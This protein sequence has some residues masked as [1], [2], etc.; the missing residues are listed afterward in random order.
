L[1][2]QIAAALTQTNW[3]QETSVMPILKRGDGFVF[4]HAQQ[5]LEVGP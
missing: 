4:Q 1:G 3:P 5:F 2:L